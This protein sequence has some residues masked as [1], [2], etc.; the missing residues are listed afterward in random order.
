MFG[1]GIYLFDPAI[2]LIAEVRAVVK[3]KKKVNIQTFTFIE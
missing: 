3:S 1:F 2:P